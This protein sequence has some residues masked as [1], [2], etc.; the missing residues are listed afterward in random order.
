MV[1]IGWN[2]YLGLKIPFLDV[3]DRGPGYVPIE[4]KIIL[5]GNVVSSG[6]STISR[7]LPSLGTTAKA[8]GGGAIL[9]TGY[10]ASQAGKR[11][12][13][14]GS[15]TKKETSINDQQSPNGT[16]PFSTFPQGEGLFGNLGA[17][18][19]KGASDIGQGLGSGLSGIGQGI[20]AG[21][22]MGLKLLAVGGL[23]YLVMR[24]RK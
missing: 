23:A 2:E 1:S 24:G 16:N 20:G 8:A 14:T 17:G 6:K 15:Y 12:F 19:G 5:G 11:F 21:S 7:F 10:E 22:E 3:F 13:E 4:K 9:Y 18:L